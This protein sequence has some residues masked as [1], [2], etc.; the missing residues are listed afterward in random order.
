VRYALE[1]GFYSNLCRLMVQN[2]I[3]SSEFF[4]CKMVRN[5]IPRIFYLPRNGSERNSEH[6]PFRGT[7]RISTELVKFPSVPCSAKFF[8]LGK[9]Q[10]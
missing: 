6:F 5:R 3:T 1:R 8:F 7:D 4:F 10:P 9:W 2:E